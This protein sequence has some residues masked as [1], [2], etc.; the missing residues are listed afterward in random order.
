LALRDD[1]RIYRLRIFSA[2][3]TLPQDFAVQSRRQRG[4]AI[5]ADPKT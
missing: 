2:S 1:P 4:F 5:P 3:G